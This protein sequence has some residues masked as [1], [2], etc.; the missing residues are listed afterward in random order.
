MKRRCVY[1]LWGN[2]PVYSSLEKA[3]N[4]LC[5]AIGEDPKSFKPYRDRINLNG[6]SVPLSNE[7]TKF[8]FN[9]YGGILSY[10]NGH[11]IYQ[12]PIL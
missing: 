1:Q 2:G 12:R 4:A 10:P 6:K 8:L 7:E 3:H 11:D 5:E 9:K